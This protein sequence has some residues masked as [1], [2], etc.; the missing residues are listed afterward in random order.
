MATLPTLQPSRFQQCPVA[1]VAYMAATQAQLQANSEEKVRFA[2]VIGFLLVILYDVRRILG[3]RPVEKVTEEVISNPQHDVIYEL[4]KRYE[5]FLFRG[6]TFSR[7]YMLNTISGF[8]QLRRCAQDTPHLPLILLVLPTMRPQR[9][10]W[11]RCKPLEK[12][13]RPPR[14]R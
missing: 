11:R 2:G 1:L 13:I 7:S 4:G 8:S 6:C 3:T 5:T 10:F 14:N 12:I 9:I